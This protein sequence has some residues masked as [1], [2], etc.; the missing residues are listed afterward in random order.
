MRRTKRAWQRLKLTIAARLVIST[1]DRPD[2]ALFSQIQA[3]KIA[4]AA[5]D[6]IALRD[7]QFPKLED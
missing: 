7:N 2:N 3:I 5:D 1:T 6:I 4:T